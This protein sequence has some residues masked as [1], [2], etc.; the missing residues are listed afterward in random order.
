MRYKL[1]L[2]SW[3]TA[4]WMLYS[5]DTHQATSDTLNYAV[6]KSELL[7]DSALHGQE[8]I[9]ES[10]IQFYKK[11]LPNQFSTRV[12]VESGAG[13]EVFLDALYDDQIDSLRE[14]SDEL[15]SIQIREM[16]DSQIVDEEYLIKSIRYALSSAGRYPWNESIPDSIFLNYL[17]P[18]K[19]I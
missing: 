9:I 3:L 8:H 7:K 1:V 5:C 19:V 4:A 17:L 16:S 13:N 14:H 2:I 10:I 12:I 11:E 6:I 15:S 18:Y